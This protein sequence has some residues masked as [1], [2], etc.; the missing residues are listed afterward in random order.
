MTD[1]KYV[2]TPTKETMQNRNDLIQGVLFLPDL[3]KSTSCNCSGY[4]S[5]TRTSFCLSVCKKPVGSVKHDTLNDTLSD[6]DVTEFLRWVRKV[7]FDFSPHVRTAAVPLRNVYFAGS[8]VTH[9]SVERPIQ[10]FGLVQMT[11]H[12]INSM[13]VA[14]GPICKQSLRSFRSSL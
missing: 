5:G 13:S 12:Y 4:T 11:Q 14:T 7:S 6:W 9:L 8:T 1:Q 10:M 3:S 2:P